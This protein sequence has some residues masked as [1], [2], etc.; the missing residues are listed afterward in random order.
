MVQESIVGE[1]LPPG[2]SGNAV[3][4]EHCGQHAP[5]FLEITMT[6][7]RDSS[8]GRFA[9]ATGG[10]TGIVNLAANALITLRE[11][12]PCSDYEFALSRTAKSR[13]SQSAVALQQHGGFLLGWP[14]RPA[15]RDL[16]NRASRKP[17]YG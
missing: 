14:K 8:T 2:T 4:P 5:D 17:R 7:D 1:I 13:S 6:I 16:H 9:G 15:R 11:R 10:G 12:L 3:P